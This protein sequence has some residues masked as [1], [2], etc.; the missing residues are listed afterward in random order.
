MARVNLTDL[1]QPG[2]WTNETLD[3]GIID[4]YARRMELVAN[5][6]AIQQQTPVERPVVT[7]SFGRAFAAQPSFPPDPSEA[8]RASA[9]IRQPPT[10]S[11]TAPRNKLATS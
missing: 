10:R 8:D 7:R 1:L 5:Q 6:Q 4:L 9:E 3:H 11:S 2:L